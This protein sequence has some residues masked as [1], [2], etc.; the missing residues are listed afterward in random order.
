M[1]QAGADGDLYPVPA[2][3]QNKAQLPYIRRLL[4]G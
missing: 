4:P 1:R 3:S 2:E